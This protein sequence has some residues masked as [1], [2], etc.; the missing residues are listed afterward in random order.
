MYKMN[1]LDCRKGGDSPHVPTDLNRGLVQGLY[2]A[3][4]KQETIARRLNIDEDTL[5]KHYRAELDDALGDI[6]NLACKVIIEKI[7][8]K[9]MKAAI[10]WLTHRAGWKPAALED[11]DN[12]NPMQFVLDLIAKGKQDEKPRATE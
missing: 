12:N 5:R 1:T 8:K 10:F 4:V 7:H 9:E 6:H 11:K 3:G 2:L